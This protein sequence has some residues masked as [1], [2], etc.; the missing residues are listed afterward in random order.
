MKTL[1]QE[2]KNID[3]MFV[4]EIINKTISLGGHFVPKV[5]ESHKHIVCV[6]TSEG[7]QKIKRFY[8]KNF[9]T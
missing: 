1:I 2:H 8:A 6:N 4:F 3:N 9:N 5:V 7:L